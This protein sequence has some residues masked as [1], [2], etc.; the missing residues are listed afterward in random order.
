MNLSCVIQSRRLWT[1]WVNTL[2]CYIIYKCFFKFTQLYLYL[3]FMYLYWMFR[4]FFKLVWRSSKVTWWTVTKICERTWKGKVFRWCNMWLIYSS[5][6]QPFRLQGTPKIHK[7]SN[8][9]VLPFRLIVSSK[10]SFN[11]NL[12]R[13]LAETI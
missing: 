3:T 5:G 9:E 13:S 6:S 12:T 8:S 7:K 2:I 10:G 11:Y 1:W 4:Q